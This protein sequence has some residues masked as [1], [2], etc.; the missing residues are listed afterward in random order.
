MQRAEDAVPLVAPP[1]RSLGCAALP[2]LLSH[3]GRHLRRQLRVL[4]LGRRARGAVRPDLPLRPARVR[5][6]GPADGA[7]HQELLRAAVLRVA[8]RQPPRRRQSR[9]LHLGAT[10]KLLEETVQRHGP[11]DGFLGFSQGGSLAHM[12]CWPRTPCPLR[13][14]ASSSSSR[15]ASRHHAH[16]ELLRR[17]ALEVP[18]FVIYNGADDHVGPDETQLISTFSPPPTVVFRKGAG[19]R[20]QAAARAR[21]RERP[22]F[23]GRGREAAA[24]VVPG[25]DKDARRR[26]CGAPRAGTS[27]VSKTLVVRRHATSCTPPWVPP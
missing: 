16:A 19:P 5:R 27:N 20:D 11:F 17:E 15:R 7:D 1:T 3:F 22:P 24:D 26:R 12:R 21:A 4:Q 9:V 25:C 10:L 14:P 23:S 13:R 6:G 2:A 18:A 8:Q